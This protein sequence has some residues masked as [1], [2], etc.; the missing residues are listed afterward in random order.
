MVITSYYLFEEYY[1]VVDIKQEPHFPVKGG[2]YSNS[3]EVVD[4]YEAV[5]NRN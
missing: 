2:L 5:Q 3:R 4:V 1:F